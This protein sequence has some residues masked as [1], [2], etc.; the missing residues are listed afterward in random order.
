MTACLDSVLQRNPALADSGV[1]DINGYAPA[2]QSIA[3]ENW[4]GEPAVDLARNRTK[5][6]FL[7]ADSIWRASRMGL[8]V[9]LPRRPLTR[10]ELLAAGARLDE[11]PVEEQGFLLQTYVRDTGTLHTTLSVPL[12]VEHQRYGIVMLGWDPANTSNLDQGS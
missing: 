7:D 11:P 10:L 2:H 12:Y 3:S 5:R 9:D 8:G 6:L 4:T 1:G